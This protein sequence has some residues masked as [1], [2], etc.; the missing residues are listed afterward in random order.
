MIGVLAIIAILAVVIVPKVFS[1][2]ASARVTNAVASV[3]SVKSAV[4][5]FAGKYGTF[6]TTN[7]NSRIDDLL[8]AQGLLESRFLVKI[9]NQPTNPAIASATWT[10]NAAGQWTSAGGASQT[11]QSR[12]I[13]LTSNTTTPN[14]AG[15][16]NFRLDGAN[17]LPA[18]SRVVSAVLVNIRASEAQDLSTRIDGEP[19]TQTDTTTAD[20]SGRVVYNTPNA[21]GFTTAYVYLAHQ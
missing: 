1:T 21:S 2:I 19:M 17:D 16:R 14:S 7:N 10:R 4:T 13:S 8:V 15:G 6:P 3:N 11:S 5:E 20:A 9:G 18:G 12:V